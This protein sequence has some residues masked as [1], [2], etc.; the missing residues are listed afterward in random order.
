MSPRKSAGARS[1]LG[2]HGTAP[3]GKWHSTGFLT[4]LASIS[5][6]GCAVL[7]QTNGD[8][9]VKMTALFTNLTATSD[10]TQGDPANGI[11]SQ[12]HHS[13]TT[14]GDTA[15]LHE[16]GGILGGLL[17]FAAKL[18]PVPAGVRD[19][20]VV[21]SPQGSPAS[22]GCPGERTTQTPAQ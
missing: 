1:D 20:G 9:H 11:V 13:I 4:T 21:A 18:L 17:A 6:A 22:T 12:T 2:R 8:E 7:E 5:L 19:Q 10:C 16:A 14:A 15:T 3:S